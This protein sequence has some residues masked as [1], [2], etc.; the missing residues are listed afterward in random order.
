M[1]LTTFINFVTTKYRKAENKNGVH[2][3]LFE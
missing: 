2:N 1:G 3:L